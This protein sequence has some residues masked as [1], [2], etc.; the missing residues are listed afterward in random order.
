MGSNEFVRRASA[1]EIARDELAAVIAGVAE[2]TLDSNEWLPR[3]SQAFPF[4]EVSDLIFWSDRTRTPAEV[5]DEIY[6]R[7]SLF[8]SGGDD[9]IQQRLVELAH[10]ALY[11]TDRPEWAHNWASIVLQG[12]GRSEIFDTT[13]A[14]HPSF[15]KVAGLWVR[16]SDD[17]IELSLNGI[18]ILALVGEPTRF[19]SYQVE[20]DDVLLV[21]PPTSKQRR[22]RLQGHQL[23]EEGFPPYHRES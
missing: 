18:A 9:A 3:L 22:L 5:V 19:W 4:A 17:V 23:I 6:V 8:E 12:G 10:A 11:D 7:K 2:G 1:G 13:R 15:E 21:E 16:T 20:G 14:T